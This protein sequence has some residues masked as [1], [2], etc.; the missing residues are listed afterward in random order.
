MWLSQWVSSNANG[1]PS[2]AGKAL[3]ISEALSI[4]AAIYSGESVE[5]LP[6][7]SGLGVFLSGSWTRST[8]FDNHPGADF[9]LLSVLTHGLTLR[10]ELCVTWDFTPQI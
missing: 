10:G 5:L 2:H 8:F 1:T 6:F 3:E 9:P 7:H 4:L